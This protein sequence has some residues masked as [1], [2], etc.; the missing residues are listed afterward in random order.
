MKVLRLNSSGADVKRW[1]QF[2]RGRGL[3]LDTTGTFD[4]ATEKTTR[5]FQ[6]THGL[7]VDGV[8]G[9]QTLTKAAE[10]GFELVNY[11]AEPDSGYPLQPGFGSL[12][13]SV[14]QSK[15]G[16]LQFVAAPTANNPEKIRITNGFETT[17]IQRVAIPEL[18]GVAGAPASGKVQI[19]V[20]AATSFQAL[21]AAWNASGYLNQ[22]LS[23]SGSYEPR[24]VRGG[25][26]K[27]TLSNHA[28]GVAFDINA[29]WNPFGAEPASPGMTGCVYDLVP[30]AN[31][32]GFFWGG[33]YKTR[34]DGMHF[35]YVG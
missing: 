4:A 20:L 27:Q 19:H 11:A 31:Q 34:R 5:K 28:F 24:F 16:P 9:N 13:P 25:A 17:K 15:F 14:A 10:L 23:F 6:S 2:L 21:W 18:V 26:A 29:E 7:V 8:V 33:H 12:T 32:H 1:Q 22:V 3:L 35:E 30:I